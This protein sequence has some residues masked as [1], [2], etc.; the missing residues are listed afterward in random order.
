MFD[1]L[2][3]HHLYGKRG[4]E[5]E[6][7]REGGRETESKNREQSLYTQ[8]CIYIMYA[9]LQMLRQGGLKGYLTAD[10]WNHQDDSH[11]ARWGLGLV[12]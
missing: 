8:L 1:Q 7:E 12:F 2:L 4:G 6:R 10:H 3:S 9:Y 5:R 11:S